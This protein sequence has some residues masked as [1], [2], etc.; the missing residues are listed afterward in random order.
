VASGALRGCV[1]TDYAITTS[2]ATAL[3]IQTVD[4]TRRGYPVESDRSGPGYHA[5]HSPTPGPPGWTVHY[6]SPRQEPGGARWRLQVPPPGL[7]RVALAAGLTGLARAAV[8]AAGALPPD[9][10]PPPAQADVLSSKE[11]LP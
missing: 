9:W 5:P 10:T 6:D 3:E 8:M 7:E 4:D 1:V 2:E 11:R